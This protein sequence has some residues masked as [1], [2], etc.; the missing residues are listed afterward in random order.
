MPLTD[1][2]GNL[3]AQGVI[4]TAQA[5]TRGGPRR[6][7]KW[8][9]R[10]ANDAN[11]M[12]RDNAI[13]SLEENKKIQNE[14]RVYDSPANQM[15]RYKAAGLNP[16]LIYGG[17]SGSSGGTFAISAPQVAPSRIDAPSAS[18]PDVAGS[19]VQAG[20]S[21]ASTQLAQQKADESETKQALIEVQ[22]DIAKANPMLNPGV[23]KA[24]TASMV[25]VAN[26]KA[27]EAKT[28]WMV[29]EKTTEHSWERYTL[30]A[31]KI[32]SEVESMIQKLGLN[33]KDLEIKN[34]ILESKEFSNAILEVQ[35]NWLKDGDITSQHVFQGL[36][37]LLSKMM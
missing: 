16:N 29:R 26:A 10:A 2:A 33:T 37:L 35:K 34:K 28:M 20:Q 23:Y 1:A 31:K 12:N 11:Q 4:A 14:Q 19:F 8:N 30:G 3:L 24:L 7:Y 27:S 15:A 25:D 18:Y 36:M 6:Q 22:T 13:W 5:I 32:E 21:L 17:G 9:K